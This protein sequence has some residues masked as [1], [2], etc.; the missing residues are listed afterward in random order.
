LRDAFLFPGGIRACLVPLGQSFL[1]GLGSAYSPGHFSPCMQH[2]EDSIRCPYLLVQA[3]Q[4]IW[5]VII[6]GVYQRFTSVGPSIRTLLP[7][8]SCWEFRLSLTS[9]PLT[10]SVVPET[11]HHRIAPVACPGRLLPTERQ[12][13]TRVMTF[14]QATFRVAL[15]NMIYICGGMNYISIQYGD[16]KGWIKKT[17]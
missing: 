11:S 15:R 3:C 4:H 9:Q 14:I 5:L 17:T 6:Y 2:L 16:A 7:T 8:P 1:N 12:V 10:G 13:M